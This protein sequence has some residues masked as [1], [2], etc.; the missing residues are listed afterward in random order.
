MT[1]MQ[2]IEPYL[3]RIAVYGWAVIPREAIRNLREAIESQAARIMVLEAAL[4][5]C[6]ECKTCCD[7]IRF[8]ATI[9]YGGPPA[10]YETCERLGV[11]AAAAL[12]EPL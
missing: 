5:P 7:N 4:R 8:E 3:P 10:V 11:R 1:P 2:T 9:D 6:G 12:T